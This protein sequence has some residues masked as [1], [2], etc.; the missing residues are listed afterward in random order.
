MVKHIRPTNSTR[1]RRVNLER[2]T[3][4]GDKITLY[5]VK[6]QK[7]IDTN[8]QTI[9]RENPSMARQTKYFRRIL[10]D[11]KKKNWFSQSEQ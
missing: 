4:I 11:G 9:G 1:R 2:Y 6:L 8:I 10:C 7:F 3:Y 5:R